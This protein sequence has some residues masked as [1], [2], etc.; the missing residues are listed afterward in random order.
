M[1]SLNAENLEFCKQK[2]QLSYHV[3][4][5]FECYQTVGFQ[6]KD[7]LEVGGSLPEGFVLDYLGAK[8]WSCLENPEY[9]LSLMEVGGGWQQASAFKGM[10]PTNLADFSFENRSLGRYNLFLAKI[11]DLPNQHYGK[12][13]LVFSIAAFEHIHKLPQALEKMYLAL[14]PGGKL[15]SM[16]APIWSSRYGHH[17]PTLTDKSGRTIDRDKNSLIPPWG[18]LIMRPPELCRHLYQLTDRETSDTIVYYVYNSDHINRFFAEDYINFIEQSSFRSIRVQHPPI[19]ESP[20][21][22]E[23]QQQLER[24]YPQRSQFSNDGFIVVLERPLD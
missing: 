18:H 13:D 12:Y 7:V 11:E 14:K 19:F 3:D 4:F 21:T 23:L 2:F 22:P 10:S 20:I 15:F 1:P 6:G 5:V 8:S 17:L 9:D 16:F 24:L